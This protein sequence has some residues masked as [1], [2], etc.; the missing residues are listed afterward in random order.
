MD[1]AE[2]ALMQNLADAGCCPSDCETFLHLSEI[3]QKAMLEKKRKDLLN[4]LHAA[5][6][7]L[8]CLDY[9]RYQYR[10]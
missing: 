6:E 7:K 10:K 4:E 2:R 9:L 8:D 1:K 5:R 3:E